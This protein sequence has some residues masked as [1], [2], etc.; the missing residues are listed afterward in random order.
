MKKLALEVGNLLKGKKQTLSV[1][2]S[3][4]G[5]LLAKYITDI[6]GSSEYF[7]LGV[8]VYSN[9]AKSN[10][11]KVDPEIIKKHGAVSEQTAIAMAVNVKQIL[12]TDWALSITGIA[13]PKSDNT[14][15]Q[16]GLVYICL[17]SANRIICKYNLFS[18][19]GRAWIRAQSVKTA[20]NV[21][22]EA[23]KGK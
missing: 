9:E 2:E 4:T 8:V 14:Q 21:L 17:V 3:C 19:K 20:L 10:L 23:L 15:K 18:D 22:K 7:K 6:S 13:G 12:N 1:A 11:L 16:V 5:G